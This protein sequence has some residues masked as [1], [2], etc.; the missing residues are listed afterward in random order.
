MRIKL[1]Q[2][3]S[4]LQKQTAPLYALFGNE[5]LLILEAADLIRDHARQHGY[6]ERALFSVDQHFDWSDLFNTSNNL[7]L[8]GD[9]RIM[10]IRIPSGKPGKDGSEALQQYADHLPDGV[11]T[12]V[13]LPRLDN[14]QLKSA[15][16]AA[17][18]RTGVSV[19]I[20]PVERGALPSWIAQRLAR[21]GQRVQEGDDGKRALAF[22]ADRVEG[23]L[24]AAH[25]EI[26]KLALLHPPGELGFDDIEAAVL[27]VARYDIR[28]LCE[29]VLAG[30]VA[31]A[32]RML[33][34][35]RAE[36]E[37]VVG[38]HWQLADDLRAL[39]RVRDAMAAGKPLPVALGEAKVWGQRQRAIERAVGQV[40]ERAAA[41]LV[42]A[43]SL[44]DGIAKGLPQPDWPADPW[45][46][47]RRLVLMTLTFTAAAPRA[48]SGGRVSLALVTRT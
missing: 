18:D 11:V 30:Q 44:C 27:D 31:R 15:W 22:F 10:D 24:L 32:L 5:P 45:E 29:A 16:F 1:E 20:D 46:A 28:Q 33:D 9:R 42:A 19:R 21:Q 6:T 48:K 43:A 47:L 41:R 3:P 17:L 8:F 2:L 14:T 34:G 12:L 26:E 35:L 38:V 39:K 4:Q 13:L 36:G 37:S 25:Q 7:S 40:P 23:N